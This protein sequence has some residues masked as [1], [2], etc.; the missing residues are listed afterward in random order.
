MAWE[1]D[2]D[3][4]GRSR[5]RACPP[6]ITDWETI[7]AGGCAGDP[8]AGRLP[9]P[10]RLRRLAG[11][12]VRAAD[13]R[14]ELSRD[15]A[16]PAAASRPTV[17]AD[18]GRERR[19]SSWFGA[20]G[21]PRATCVALG[22][23]TVEAQERLRPRLE[24]TSS[25]CCGIYQALDGVQPRPA[26]PH[27]C[28]APTRFPSEMRKDRRGLSSRC[29]SSELIPEVG[30]RGWPG[31]A[32]YSWR[33]RP[34][35]VDEARRIFAAGTARG[36]GPKLHADQLTRR[37]GAEL[38]AEVGAVSADHLEHASEDGNPGRWHGPGWWR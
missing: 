10:S 33:T 26:G 38:A 35:R 7:D 30:G 27:V 6:N 17:R 31:S 29:S 15:R 18:P 3:P 20:A 34:S 13:P 16:R 14:A 5:R 12:G 25:G 4:V 11:R 36:L 32:T 19:R 24:S 2:I 9:H 22:V 23:T 8:G 37:G 21:A 1:G 28:S